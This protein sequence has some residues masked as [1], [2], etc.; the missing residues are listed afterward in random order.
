MFKNKRQQ[1]IK[2]VIQHVNIVKTSGTN[3]QQ[4]WLLDHVTT[5][6]PTTMLGHPPIVTTIEKHRSC[7]RRTTRKN[8]YRLHVHNMR[9][10]TEKYAHSRKY[11]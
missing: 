7:D 2:I 8:T 1:I 10:K 3:R 6:S 11:V 4:T 9:A 5:R